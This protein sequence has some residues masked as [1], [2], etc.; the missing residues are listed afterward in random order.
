MGLGTLYIIVTPHDE[1]VI[2]SVALLGEES[3]LFILS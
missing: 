2:N 3:L 1:N